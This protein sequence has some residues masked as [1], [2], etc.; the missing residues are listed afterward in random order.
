MSSKLET[1]IVFGAFYTF[2]LDYVLDSVLCIL[3]STNAEVFFVP[4]NIG[5]ICCPE[6]SITTIV[7][8]V[9]SQK[10]EDILS[11]SFILTGAREE[12]V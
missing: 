6:T 4:M 10:I 1:F 3:L 8:C 9:T 11:S 5:L 7:R 2:T 12:N